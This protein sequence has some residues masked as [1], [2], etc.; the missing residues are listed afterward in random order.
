MIDEKTLL[1]ITQIVLV[2]AAIN[3]GLVAYNGTDLVTLTVGK[4][5]KIAKLVVGIVGVY[6]AYKLYEAN[7]PVDEQT[8]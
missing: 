2:V 6:A 7:K 4:F 3:W 8:A 1:L 5:D